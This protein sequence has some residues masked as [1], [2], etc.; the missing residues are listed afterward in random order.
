MEV[1][2]ERESPLILV[3]DDDPTIRKVG[4]AILEYCGCRGGSFRKRT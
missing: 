3:V 1:K 4:K 2:V